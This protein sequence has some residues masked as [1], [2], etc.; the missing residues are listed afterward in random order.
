MM[1]ISLR[2]GR[3]GP[4]PGIIYARA[5]DGRELPVVDVTN[6][7]FALAMSDAEQAA[8]VE[9][10]ARQQ[11]PFDV[12]PARLRRLV[13]RFFLRGSV[14]ARG[15][16]GARGTFLRGMD[17]YLFKLGPEHLGPAYPR[18]RARAKAI[19]RR[20]AAALPAMAIRLR[21]QDMAQLLADALGPAL[22]ARPEA[23]L[24]LVSIAGG[25]AM[26]AINALLLV[27]RA[28]P[29]A[30]ARRDVQIDVLDL[31]E[32][33]PAFGARALAALA[34]PG[35]PLQGVRAT[36]RPVRYDW[37]DTGLLQAV[38]EGARAA[39]AVAAGSSEGGLFEYG[40]DDEIVANLACMRDA[41]PP[42][43]VMVGSVT[44][45]DELTRRL[46][47][48]S[49]AALRPRGLAVFEALAAR[50]GWRTARA[51]PRPFSDHVAL[52]RSQATF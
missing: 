17:T 23:P 31:D 9:G 15:I 4:E 38:L 18:P 22:A 29:G 36:L 2:F 24:R 8:L 10:F 46:H 42:G 25:P 6:P 45:A 7:A 12:L 5:V 1:R 48:Q 52:V 43:Y 50:A 30:L 35:A 37:T 39:G 44:R 26:D 28:Q 27:R 47:A 13:M 21:L 40:S 41:A 14:L 20:I 32:D 33:G 19:D 3:P 16:R 51:I 49:G 11:Q 34:A